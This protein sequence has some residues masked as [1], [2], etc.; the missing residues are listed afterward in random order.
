M[1]RLDDLS[2]RLF[3]AISNNDLDAIT[4]L[5]AEGAKADHPVA[6]EDSDHE[7]TPVFHA[8]QLGMAHL[9]E[10][11]IGTGWKTVPLAMILSMG[12]E[13][14][15]YEAIVERC[16]RIVYTES[17]ELL[18]NCLDVEAPAVANAMWNAASM[19]L[20]PVNDNAHPSSVCVDCAT[21]I[22]WEGGYPEKSSDYTRLLGI[23]TDTMKDGAIP[24][25]FLDN[26]PGQCE[27][28]YDRWFEHGLSPS[29]NVSGMP[30]LHTFAYNDETDLIALALDAGASVE[31]S[32][33]YADFDRNFP[34]SVRKCAMVVGQPVSVTDAARA[35]DSPG[36]LQVIEA[37]RAKL[38]V[39][40][41]LTAARARKNP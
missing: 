14:D 26:L 22:L 17:V 16:D 39:D 37:H 1:T 35:G 21:T 34:A 6:T 5:K 24:V 23:E 30:L 18:S 29:A 19:A 12:R 7:I 25:V 8:I 10:P 3:T 38:A 15:L 11:L 28:I 32:C 20:D 33:S 41:V 13:Y 31:E 36:A 27:H 40:S 4:L 9:I 2:R